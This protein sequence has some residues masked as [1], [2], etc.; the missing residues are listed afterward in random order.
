[1]I[2]IVNMSHG[3]HE[4]WIM[5]VAKAMATSIIITNYTDITNYMNIMN[6][7]NI[8]DCMNI[9]NY[10]NIMNYM[11]MKILNMNIMNMERDRDTGVEIH[12]L[13][14]GRN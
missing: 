12:G 10:V 14:H 3:D 1:M 4:P 7:I 8:M 9:M 6:Y 11:N 13:G 5:E 2:I